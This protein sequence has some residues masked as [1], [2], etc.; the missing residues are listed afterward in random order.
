M[1]DIRFY[2]LSMIVLVSDES[3]G[4][5]KFLTLV[6]LYGLHGFSRLPLYKVQLEQPESPDSESQSNR[7][8]AH[9]YG[10]F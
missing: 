5:S 2:L 7:K 8:N 9:Y 3:F 1:P 4:V 6:F 10:P